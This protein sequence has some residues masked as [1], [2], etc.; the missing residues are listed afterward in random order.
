MTAASMS[1]GT[2]ALADSG[3]VDLARLRTDR[4]RRLFD[5]MADYELDVLVLGRP[6]D[7]AFATGARQLWTAGTRP[8]GPA[9]VVVRE[10]GRTHLLSVWDE[11]V[12]PE[13][14]HD[15]LYG[16]AWNPANLMASLRE[17]PG[18]AGARRVGTGSLTPGFSRF[19]TALAPEA[20]VVDGCPAIW[21]A[22]TPKSPDEL[23]C[24]ATATAIAES[25]LTA[26]VAALQPGA[27]E[28]DL[29]GVYVEHIASHGAPTPP[30]EGVACATS[31]SAPVR[32]RRLATDRPIDRDDLV[33][34]DPGAM[35]AGYEGGIG[36]TRLA[37]ASPLDGAPRDLAA[38]CGAVL[39][40]VIA[41]CRPGATGADLRQAWE[42]TGEALPEVPFVHGVGLG[43]EPPVVGGGVGDDAVLSPGVVLSVSAWVGVEGVGGWF[44][45]DIVVVAGDGPPEVLSRY[46]RGPAGEGT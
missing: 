8:S 40:G 12:P 4:R 27:T 35:F 44:E 11:G 6:A 3:R 10:T 30:T 29:L 13:L 32:L 37:G 33:V 18:L 19:V 25:A 5:A 38:R 26:M 34:L 21:A 7:V 45:R 41:A 28:R 15:D 46:G 20:S 23:A 39:D 1:L 42:A 17:I 2:M 22:R 31:R 9:C 16:L 14:T 24:I 43:A 36:R